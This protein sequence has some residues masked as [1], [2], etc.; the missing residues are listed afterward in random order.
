MQEQFLEGMLRVEMFD[1]VAGGCG[2]HCML[3]GVGPWHRLE[4]PAVAFLW[5]K[6]GEEVPICQTHLDE[7]RASIQAHERR[8]AD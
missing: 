1:E 7:I 4:V 5:F 2:Y 6:R 8:K 3:C